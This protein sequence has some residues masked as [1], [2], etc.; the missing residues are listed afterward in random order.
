MSK[1]K[2]FSLSD[3][4]AGI[5]SGMA[6]TAVSHPFDLIKVKMQTQPTLFPTSIKTI[7]RVFNTEGVKHGCAFVNS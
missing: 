2:S 3:F 1:K 6:G 7:I 5:L 4:S